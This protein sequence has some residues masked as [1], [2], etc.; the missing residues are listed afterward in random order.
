MRLGKL[1][2]LVTLGLALGTFMAPAVATE[3]SAYVGINIG[4]SNFEIDEAELADLAGYSTSIDDSDT[5]W[6]LAAGYRFA[7]YFRR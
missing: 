7:P 5:A 3:S 6:S 2:Y 4:Q 1:S